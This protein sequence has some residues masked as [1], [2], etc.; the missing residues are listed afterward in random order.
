MGKETTQGKPWA[1]LYAPHGLRELRRTRDPPRL[2]ST[3]HRVIKARTGKGL[4]A[5]D[6]S[7]TPEGLKLSPGQTGNLGLSHLIAKSAWNSNYMRNACG[8]GIFCSADDDNIVPPVLR[9]LLNVYSPKTIQKI[10]HDYDTISCER[11]AVTM[12]KDEEAG[13]IKLQLKSPVPKPANCFDLHSN[14]KGANLLAKGLSLDAD[15]LQVTGP[16]VDITN[17]QAPNEGVKHQG[18]HTVHRL[19][20]A[21]AFRVLLGGGNKVGGNTGVAA[22]VVSPSGQ[23]LCWGKKN[24]AHPVLHAEASA[25]LAYGEKLPKG[26]RIYSTLKP[27]KMCRA[28]IQHFSSGDDFVVYFGQNDPTLAAMG[29]MDASKFVLLSN[30]AADKPEKPIWADSDKSRPSELRDTVAGKLNTQYGSL[31]D[32]EKELGIINFIKGGKA[33]LQLSKAA[34]YLQVKQ[35]KYTNERLATTYNEN[36]KKCLGHITEVL[37]ELGLPVPVKL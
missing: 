26:V 28:F 24:S 22:L 31:H 3:R 6:S 2:T 12:I 37:K 1:L 20:M 32:K 7:Q 36:V 8:G 9:I 14:R 29:P 15:K 23:I 17:R 34:N 21:A 13:K 5:S 27:C 19:Y 4:L 10:E 11:A 16:N 25:L 35:L 18:V 33:N 30:S